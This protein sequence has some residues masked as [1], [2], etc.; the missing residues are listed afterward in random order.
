MH[1]R[2]VG[3]DRKKLIVNFCLGRFFNVVFWQMVFLE[4][5]KLWDRLIRIFFSVLL[6]DG[7]D[8]KQSL[9]MNIIGYM[10]QLLLLDSADPAN[11]SL[12]HDSEDLLDYHKWEAKT[13]QK[14]KVG[15]L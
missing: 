2:H 10:E 9:L 14:Y 11:S 12:V 5:L 3:K 1:F 15:V 7:F 8:T 13:T 6:T 4:D